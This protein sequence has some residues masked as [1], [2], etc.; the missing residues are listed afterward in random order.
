M[1]AIEVGHSRISHGHGAEPL[2]PGKIFNMAKYLKTK[3]SINCNDCPRAVTAKLLL[4]SHP[5]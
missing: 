4:T 3:F 5:I 1:Y 2:F